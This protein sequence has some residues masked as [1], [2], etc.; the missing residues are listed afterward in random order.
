M[1]L[2][3]LFA[4]LDRSDVIRAEH[5]MAALAVWQH[6]EASA[7]YI[8]GSKLGDPTA[9]ELQ[10]LLRAAG[11]QGRT[12]DEI[13]EHFSR[14][15]RA[16]EISRALAVL[17]EEGRARRTEKPDTGGRPAEVWIANI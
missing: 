13:R 7:R 14:H 10:Q 3:L 11:E 1:R 4:L 6:A 9:D 2:A 5:L 12:R 15:K 16:D 8:F 17:A